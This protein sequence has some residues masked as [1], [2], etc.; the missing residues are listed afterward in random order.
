MMNKIKFYPTIW[1]AAPFTYNIMS[2]W[3]T[4]DKTVKELILK[5][6]STKELGVSEMNLN[7]TKFTA[8][9]V[10]GKEHHITDFPGQ[11]PV[12]LKGM[13]SGRYLK[14]ATVVGLKPGTYAILRFYLGTSDNKFAY[15]D[16]TPGV[17]NNLN[18]VDFEIEKRLIIKKGEKAE[19][20]LWFDLAPFQFSRHFKPLVDWLKRTK[21]QL[22]RLANNLG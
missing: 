18:H 22:P 15:S 11:N 3:Y 10:A 1:T 9:D 13:G 6:S 4:T 5:N 2:H 16:G 20:K 7:I 19:V 14:S 17:A 8:F 12:T 21:K